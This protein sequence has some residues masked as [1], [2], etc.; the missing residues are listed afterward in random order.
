MSCILAVF[1]LL[2]NL[3]NTIKIIWILGS[4]AAEAGFATLLHEAT[5]VSHFPVKHNDSL[6]KLLTTINDVKVITSDR[7]H[8]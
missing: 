6:T 7:D 5:L 3:G 8:V 4:S 1:W 2:I